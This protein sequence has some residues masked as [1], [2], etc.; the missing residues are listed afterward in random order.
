MEKNCQR[1][2]KK[3]ISMVVRKG[4]DVSTLIVDIRNYVCVQVIELFLINL[5]LIIVVF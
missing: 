5:K 3:K 2:Q 4:C 1:L